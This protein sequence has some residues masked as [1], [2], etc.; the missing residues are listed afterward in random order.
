MDCAPSGTDAC[1]FAIDC[2]YVLQLRR[3]ETGWIGQMY[4]VE[5]LNELSEAAF[6]IDEDAR[7]VNWSPGAE[8]LLGYS[9]KSAIGAFCSEILRG[10]HTS[11]EPMCGPMCE[12]VDCLKMGKPHSVDACLLRHKDGYVFPARMISLPLK[13]DHDRPGAKCATAILFMQNTETAVPAFPPQQLKVFTLGRFSL[14]SSGKGMAADNW[15]RKQAVTVLKFLIGRVNHPVHRDELIETIWPDA[16]SIRGWDRLKVT[17]SFLRSQLQQSGVAIDPVL[18]LDQ[19]YMLRGDVVWIDFVE[20]ERLVT[21]GNRH[22]Q[23]KRIDE[24]L[25]C[26]EDADRLYRGDFL[27]DDPHID[28]CIRERERLRECYFDMLAGMAECQAAKGDH[29]AAAQSCQRALYRDQSRESF[30]RNLI[31]S[32]GKIDQSAWKKSQREFWQRLQKKEFKMVPK[33]EHLKIYEELIQANK[34][35]PENLE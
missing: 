11:G 9:A 4:L 22:L 24:A 12:T 17:I 15:K 16:E 18:T 14:V 10:I 5:T 29:R 30:L 27:E 35:D 6:A 26:F 7:I 33:P 25:A 28:W 13:R 34:K 19:S 2:R 8:E 32:L 1:A 3:R 20:F 31:D 21:A 23:D